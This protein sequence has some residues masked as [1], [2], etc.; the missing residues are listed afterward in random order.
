[1]PLLKK[2]V[3]LKPEI[4]DADTDREV[5]LLFRALI[6]CHGRTEDYMK[7]VDRILVES[8]PRKNTLLNSFTYKDG[9]PVPAQEVIR[10]FS[11][12][13]KMLADVGYDLC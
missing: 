1:M 8:N 5:R 7:E 9:T 11:L 2:Q 3:Y 10:I 13:K 12:Y 6:E 4:R